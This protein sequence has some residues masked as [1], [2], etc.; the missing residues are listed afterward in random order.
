MIRPLHLGLAG[1]ATVAALALV[2]PVPAPG[3]APLAVGPVAF[4]KAAPVAPVAAAAVA[5]GHDRVVSAVPAAATPAVRDGEVQALLEADGLGLAGGTFTTVA[6]PGGA[7]ERRASLVGFDLQTG[8]LSTTF[9]PVLNGPVE[10]LAA[11]PRPGTVYVGGRFTQVNGVPV[12]RVALLRTSDGMLDPTFRAAATNGAVLDVALSG[13]RLYVG[14]S[15]TTV[16]G[17]AHRGLA[18]L[19]ASTGALDPFLGVQLTE[20]HNT[21][22]GGAQGAVGARDLDVTPDGTRVVVVGNFRRADGVLRDQVAMLDTS[23]AAARVSTTWATTAFTPLCNSAK[24]DAY[25][26]A[27]SLSPDGSYFVVTTTGGPYGS[28]LCDTATRWETRASGTTLAPTWTAASG[29]DSLWGVA[30]TEAAVYV[31]GHQRWMNNSLGSDRAQAGAVPRPGVAALD[32]VS[33][34]PLRWNPGRNPRGQAVYEIYASSRG[35]WLG[36]DTEF[37]GNRTYRRPRLAFFPLAGGTPVAGASQ[38]PLPAPVYLLGGTTSDTVRRVTFTGTAVQG[39]A[40]DLGTL[41]VTWSRT[42][43]AVLLG[44]TLFYGWDDGSLYRRP[45]ADGALGTA[46]RID[47]YHDPAWSSVQTG[48]GQTYDGVT[49]ALHGQLSG[50]TGMAYAAGR[51]YYTRTGDAALYWRWFSPDTGIAGSHVYTASAGTSWSDT[52][53]LFASGGVLYRV[54]GS[55]GQLRAYPLAG[56]TPTGSGTVVGA[57]IDWRARGLV[58]DAG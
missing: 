12:A 58:V 34:I 13:N 40:A 49:S 46:T 57:G 15:F 41:G 21:T 48:S 20:R 25:V 22:G 45:F 11:G 37:I 1:L 9:K 19:D 53:G 33:G 43:G 36:S 17:V 29:G 31:G 28:T 2:A 3:A 10:T 50:L 39:T 38:D 54:I 7:D 56:A 42:R 27:V 23:G 6:G 8:A 44:G 35:L 30:V 32:P 16:G 4:A 52:R 51:L 5:P 47:P 55:T 18:T 24:F 26:R 14:G